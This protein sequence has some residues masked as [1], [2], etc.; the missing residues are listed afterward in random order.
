MPAKNVP[1]GDTT[2][3]DTNEPKAPQSVRETI[4]ASLKELENVDNTNEETEDNLEASGDIEDEDPAGEGV[5]EDKK[6]SKKKEKE[7]EEDT[8]LEATSEEEETEEETPEEK[9][10]KTKKAQVEAAPENWKGDAD[11]DKTP[12]SIRAKIIKRESEV[13]EGFKQ[14]GAKAREFDKYEQFIG[15]RRQSMAKIGVTPEQ[16]V[17]RAL[18]W[19]DAL[20]HSDQGTRVNSFKLLA[21][22][23]GIDVSQLVE[24]NATGESFRVANDGTQQGDL[25]PQVKQYISSL[26]QRLG[27]FEQRLGG[28]AETYTSQ[29]DRAAAQ[30]LSQWAKDKPHFEKVQKE[31]V[32]LI[33]G[34]AVP[35]TA[36]GS[37][38]LDTAYD[39]AIRA[40]PEVRQLLEAEA[41]K[42]AREDA[43]AKARAA[44]ANKQQQLSKARAAGGSLKPGAP[45]MSNG[46]TDPRGLSVR[47]TIRLS[48]K[49]MTN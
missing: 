3:T 11:W 5:L 10:V 17:G 34:G 45:S 44:K 27:Q 16:V 26:E 8:E 40:N 20:G 15:P 12:A 37:L 6:P 23:F 24:D 32:A 46:K 39:M 2:N 22:N 35:L 30:Y 43:A 36:D 9:P 38:D 1:A 14:Y 29:Q 7:E 47:D 49:Q 19:M 28:L 41:T 21:R 25:P 48:L 33:Q 42:K 18:E 4:Q 31:M 13:S